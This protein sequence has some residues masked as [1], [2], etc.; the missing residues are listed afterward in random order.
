MEYWL[1]RWDW[2]R[3]Y[4]Q[5]HFF[6]ILQKNTV[7]AIHT[8]YYDCNFIPINILISS[9]FLWIYFIS[10]V[11]GPFLIISPASTLHNWQQEMARFV[12][13]FKVVPY[14]GSPQV[15]RISLN[16]YLEKLFFCGSKRHST[17]HLKLWF[18]TFEGFVFFLFCL[19]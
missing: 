13:A 10:D 17:C 7:S 5:L 1:M 14:W 19:C 2:A 18:S 15:W 8:S 11:W 3:L 4:S 9:E 16:T 12:P 6:A